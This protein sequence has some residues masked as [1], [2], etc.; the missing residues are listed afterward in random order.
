MKR[1]GRRRGRADYVEA[2][3]KMQTVLAPHARYVLLDETENRWKLV[4]AAEYQKHFRTQRLGR[5]GILELF[6]CGAQ[7]SE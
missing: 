6:V 4:D 7:Y 5:W 1:T 2:F 3:G